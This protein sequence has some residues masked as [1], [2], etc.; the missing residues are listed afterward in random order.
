M[1]LHLRNG[2]VRISLLIELFL[3]DIGARFKQFRT[4]LV[5]FLSGFG[6]DLDGFGAVI[7]RLW[8]DVGTD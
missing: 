8:I 4:I 2:P 1:H 6:T 7:E 3:K 5:G